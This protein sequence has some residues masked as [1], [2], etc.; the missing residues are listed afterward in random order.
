[1]RFSLAFLTAAVATIVAAQANDGPNAFNV[2][3]GGY[4]LHA[5][6]PTT[7]TWSNQQGSTVTILLRDGANG[8][9]NAGTTVVANLDNKGTYTYT[10][11]ANIVEG[12]SYT[13]EIV[14]DQSPN[15][16]NYTGQ[17]D[18]VSPVKAVPT[19]TNAVTS[20]GA[21]TATG[22]SST[23]TQTATT[24]AT[25]LSTL[26]S[27]G[28]AT[29]NST[30]GA[31]SSSGSSASNTASNTAGNMASSSPSSTAAVTTSAPSTGAGAIVRV[32]G[33][34][35]MLAVVAVFAMAL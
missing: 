10:P 20:T 27:S 17:F 6:Q 24:T 16:T 31:S 21:A 13:L 19:G 29:G 12:N 3:P 8:D 28:S 32:G 15:E 26:T 2:P 23:A 35:A 4:L 5:G 14:N 11:P 34:G 25:G 7:F 18:I 30:S 9:L 1:M 33:A 22:S